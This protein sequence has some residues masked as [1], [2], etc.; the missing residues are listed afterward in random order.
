[1]QLQGTG[2]ITRFKQRSSCI[3]SFRAPV[4]FS[5]TETEK[6]LRQPLLNEINAQKQ[7]IEQRIQA[8]VEATGE[9]GENHQQA[10]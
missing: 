9:E 3:F 2:N 5:N 6:A 4:F 1:M 10:P 8:A 7:L